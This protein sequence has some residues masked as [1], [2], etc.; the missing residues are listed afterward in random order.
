MPRDINFWTLRKKNL[1]YFLFFFLLSVMT[2]N[3]CL[4]SRSWLLKIVSQTLGSPGFWDNPA[5]K[6][7]LLVLRGSLGQERVSRHKKVNVEAERS[8]LILVSSNLM[9]LHT[10]VLGPQSGLFS[11]LMWPCQF[12]SKLGYVY[13]HL[14][15][16]RHFGLGI[17]WWDL[18]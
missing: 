6:S 12:P 9:S 5:I 4:T 17:F 16:H 18:C 3:Y 15:W 8:G 13:S 1:T 2:E 10:L 7:L 11:S 14:C